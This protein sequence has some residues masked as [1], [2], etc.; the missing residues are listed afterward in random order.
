MSFCDNFMLFSFETLY[1]LPISYIHPFNESAL[2]FLNFRFKCFMS[3][4][5]TQGRSQGA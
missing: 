4:K 3:L 5:V 1:T 2:C